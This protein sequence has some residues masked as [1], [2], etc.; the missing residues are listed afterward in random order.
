[1]SNATEAQI[2]FNLPELSRPN[3]PV[4]LEAFHYRFFPAWALFLTLVS[5]PDVIHVEASAVAPPGAIGKDDIRFNYPLAGGAMMD[6]GTY[7]LSALRQI[8]GTE[9]EEC[10]SCDTQSYT[11]GNQAKCDYAFAAKF[12]FPN[13]AI[14]DMKGSL[15]GSWAVKLPRATVTHREVAVPDESLP[16]GQEKLRTR[17]LTMWNFM[18]S[19]IYHRID[20]VDSYVIRSKSDGTTI[21]KWT[22]KTYRKAYSFKEAGG[23]FEELPSEIYWMSYRHQLQQFVNRVKGRETLH[24]VTGEDSIAQMKMMDMAYE[25]SGL[26]ARLTSSFR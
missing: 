16:E 4:L 2:L 7:C 14:G 20:I 19:T 21:K 23:E 13:G 10:L 6:I 24:W 15:R 25:K 17:E 18:V 11:E 26:G 12:R 8:F 9:P 3:A 22:E 1:M 5:P